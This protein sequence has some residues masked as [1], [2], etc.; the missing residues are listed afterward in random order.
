[1]EPQSS[2]M[3]SGSAINNGG[4][5]DDDDLLGEPLLI[6]DMPGDRTDGAGKKRP[7]LTMRALASIAAIGGANICEF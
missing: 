6:G 7:G 5:T 3:N 2:A 1:M 4:V